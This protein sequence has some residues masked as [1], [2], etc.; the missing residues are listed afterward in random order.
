VGDEEQ[1]TD[2]I[3]DCTID[4]APLPFQVLDAVGRILAVN[5]HWEELTG[6]SAG[7]MVG[8]EFTELVPEEYHE[9]FRGKWT[10]LAQTG[11]LSGADCFLRRKDGIVLNVRVFSTLH[12]HAEAADCMLVDITGFR[13]TER[14]LKESE[15]RFRSLFMLEPT[16][17]LIHDGAKTV[18]ANP[19]CAAFLGY[20]SADELTGVSVG[21]LSLIH[22]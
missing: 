19:A 8:H 15:E 1:M 17:I 21:D 7:E 2:N 3:R 16:P 6:Y 5:G 10:V 13:Q 18:L 9:S 20:E 22:I 4:R 11:E 12:A 14:D